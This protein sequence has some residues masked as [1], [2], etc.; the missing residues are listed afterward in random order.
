MSSRLF[1][2]NK[3]QYPWIWLSWDTCLHTIQLP[4]RLLGIISCENSPVHFTK[5]QKMKIHTYGF[6]QILVNVI[7]K[8]RQGI[9]A[10]QLIIDVAKRG[11]VLGLHLRRKKLHIYLWVLT[12]V[13]KTT[14]KLIKQMFKFKTLKIELKILLIIN[15]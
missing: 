6:F 2:R 12:C 15:F 1:P 5:R 3:R 11:L 4:N 10:I 14:T 7:L 13:L 8:V 9:Q